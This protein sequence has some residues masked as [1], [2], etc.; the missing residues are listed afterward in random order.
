[1]LCAREVAVYH[2]TKCVVK[3]IRDILEVMLVLN[4]I[5]KVYYHNLEVVEALL[6]WCAISCVVSPGI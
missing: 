2:V 3:E 5:Y 6:M 1:M 4:G